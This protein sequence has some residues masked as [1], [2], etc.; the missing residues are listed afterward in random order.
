[1]IIE[2][3][4]IVVGSSLDAVVFS[5]NNRFP[6]F[7]SDIERP[8]RFDFLEHDL[9]LSFLKIPNEKNILT[10]FEGDEEVGIKKEVLWERLLFLLSLD[11]N[12]PTSNLCTNIRHDSSSITCFNEYAK[13]AEVRYERVHDFTN[14]NAGDKLL[15]CDWVAF[16]SGGKHNIDLIQTEDD[17]V[18]K[19]WFYPSDRIC[20]N[21][22]VKDAC[23]ISRISRDTIDDFD[24]SETMAR[25][26]IVKEMEK[27][28][29]KGLLSSY[30]PNGRPKHYKFKTS[31]ITR[32]K[33][34]YDSV[35]D[36]QQ[37]NK[38]NERSFNYRKYLRHL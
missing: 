9:D 28:G 27:R 21:T 11:G 23:A 25:F 15:C 16:N 22:K 20:G 24:Y 2:H 12:V 36:P 35:V 32:Q 17:F 6:I 1:M 34:I 30:G 37:F 33:N 14:K 3:R 31:T 10:S 7:F 29:M 13:I 26:K 8:F 19:I 5:F 4:D 18:N 38:L